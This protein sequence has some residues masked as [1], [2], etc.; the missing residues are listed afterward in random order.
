M[1]PVHT[2]Y[3]MQLTQ[4]FPKKTMN[5]YDL[6]PDELKKV[7]WNPQRNEDAIVIIKQPDGNFR[8]FM[9]KN[10]AFIQVRQG[11]PNTVLNLLITHP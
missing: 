10:G 3:K 4:A 9:Q 6:T 8:G 2:V 7:V 11:D 5:N 1:A